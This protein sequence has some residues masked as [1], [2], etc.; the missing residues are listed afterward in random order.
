MIV[1]MVASYVRPYIYG[2]GSI[3]HIVSSIVIDRT[4]SIDIG[5]IVAVLSTRINLFSELLG[6]TYMYTAHTKSSP[7]LYINIIN[8]YIYV[9][10]NSEAL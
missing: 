10:V 4:T 2:S 7:V 8:T 3:Y 9:S 5:T 6:G 1:K